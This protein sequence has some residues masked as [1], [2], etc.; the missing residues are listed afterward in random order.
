MTAA[1]ARF[2]F[3]EHPLTTIEYKGQPVWIAREIGRALGYASDGKA[4]LTSMARWEAEMIPGQ[5]VL[6]IDGEE[7]AALKE[8]LGADTK[9]VSELLTPF[10]QAKSLTLLTES[11]LHLVCL[12]TEQPV[13]IR[14]RRWLVDEVLP[15]LAR[16]GRYGG[17]WR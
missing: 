2:S 9:G 16:T 15:Q 10:R 13:G 3:E 17:V 11:G 1:I 4:L 7:L 5:D 14:L 8:L 6:T 12:K